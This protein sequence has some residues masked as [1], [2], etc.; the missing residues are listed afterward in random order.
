ML[1]A[2]Q[3]AIGNL[4]HDLRQVMNL[5]QEKFAA[6]LGVTFPTINRWE[7]GHA[8]PSPLAL[9]QIHVLLEQL[10]ERGKTLRTKHFPQAE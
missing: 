9:K 5:S 7:K 10:G 2:K 8:T 3:P 4:V 6:E 1:K